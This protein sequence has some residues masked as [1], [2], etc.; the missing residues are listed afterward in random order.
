M[1]FGLSGT[2]TIGHRL[3][4]VHRDNEGRVWYTHIK[5]VDCKESVIKLQRT[6]PQRRTIAW[7][8]VK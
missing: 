8:M 6:K 1:G 5:D 2:V 7:R 3:L 4:V